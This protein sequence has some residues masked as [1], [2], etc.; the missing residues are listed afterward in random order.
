M[1]IEE[2]FAVEIPDA[3]ADAINSVDQG[4]L[5]S[6]PASLCATASQLHHTRAFLHLLALGPAAMT[7]LGHTWLHLGLSI[8]VPRFRVPNSKH[9]T[10]VTLLTPQLS[11]TLS[12]FVLMWSRWRQEVPAAPTRPPIP[13]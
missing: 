5:L 13:T 2:E 11:S 3:E 1:A 12:R 4:A 8:Y 7:E 6:M 10:L 9:P